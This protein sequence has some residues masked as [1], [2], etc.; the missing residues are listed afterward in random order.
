MIWRHLLAAACVTASGTQAQ[1]VPEQQKP[2]V[3]VDHGAHTV[4]THQSYPNHRLRLTTG[5]LEQVYQRGEHAPDPLLQQVCP[6]VHGYITGYLDSGD[7]HFYF[8]YFESR[9]KPQQDP[10][11]MW[12]NGGPGCSSMMGL[13]MELGPC[14]VDEGGKTARNNENSWTN[15]ANMFFLDQPIGVGFSYSDNP[16]HHANGTFAASEDIYIFMQLWYHAFPQTKAL[17]FSIAGESC[18]LPCRCTTLGT[19]ANTSQTAGTT[20]PSSPAISTT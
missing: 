3:Q 14:A 12:I 8:A 16:D 15:A 11:V 17:P 5:T 20:S 7:K 9:S 18:R 4:V 13:L 1:A 2:L 6:G 10:L 19:T